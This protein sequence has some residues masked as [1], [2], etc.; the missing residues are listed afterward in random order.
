MQIIEDAKTELKRQYSEEIKK[1]VVTFANT[2]GG[3]I[4]VGIDDDGGVIGIENIDDTQL[5]ISSAIRDSIKPDIS[6]FVAYQTEQIEGKTILK[7]IVQKGTASPYYLTNKGLRPEGV[8]I[9]HGAASVP[10]TE[11]AIKTMIKNTD[12]D[13]YESVRSLNQNLTFDY[14][15][16]EFKKAN[17]D[18]GSSQQKTLKLSGLD[19]VYTNLGLLI[20]DQCPHII[21]IAVFEGQEKEVFKNRKELSGSLLK[22]ANDAAD[23]IDI[24]N[25]THS[26]I[27]GLRR[28]DTRDYPIEAIRESLLNAIVHREYS[29]SSGILISIFDNRIEFVSP[30]GLVSGI[31]IDAVMLGLSATRNPNLANVFYRLEYIEAY[32]IGIPRIFKSYENS[33]KKPIIN[34]VSGAFKMTL[35]NINKNNDKQ[36]QNQ[37]NNLTRK[38]QAIIDLLKEKKQ[39]SRRDIETALSSSRS[40]ISRNLKGLLDLGIIKNDGNGRATMYFCEETKGNKYGRETP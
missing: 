8:Y 32:G 28:N 4:Y 25:Q 29:L 5:Q 31:S 36:E 38:E 10:S 1:T 11:S 21:K 20:S 22:Q 7:I 12:G 27:D 17:I 14:A 34:A 3:I 23:F 33:I 37:K 26:E 13:S 39:A 40:V 24:Y 18:F 35:P 19:G 16:G 2:D 9:R 6:L 30:G 15:S